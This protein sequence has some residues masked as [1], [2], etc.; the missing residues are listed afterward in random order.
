MPGSVQHTFTHFR[1]ELTVYRSLV[2][3]ETALDLWADPA[4]CRWVHRSELA[5]EAL[6]SVMHKIVAHALRN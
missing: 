2:P 4:R 1:L 6:P 3:I 5:S